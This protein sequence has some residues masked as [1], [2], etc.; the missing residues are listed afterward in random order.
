MT[1]T[2][3]VTLI[4]LDGARPDVFRQLADRGDLPNLSRHLLD[5]PGGGTAS[6]TT[7]FPST[8][9]VAY[10]PF[11]TGCYPGTCDIPGIRWL[12]RRRYRGRWWRD[13]E[14]VR[15]YCGYQRD[16]F[17]RDLPAGVVS[18]FDLEPD[19]VALCT[20]FTRGLGAGREG[21]RRARALWG[22]LAHY[23]RGYGMLERAVGAALVESAPRRHRFSFVVFPGVDGITH[24]Y[25]PEH[26]RVLATYR[27]FDR[28]FGEFVAAAGGNGGPD[29]DHLILVASD[30]GL[31]TVA[32]HTDIALALEHLGIPTLRHPFHL[33]RRRPGAAVMVSGNASA[34]VYFHPGAPRRERYPV[35]ALEA[36]LDGVPPGIASRL[37][38]LPG[39]ALVAGTEGAEVVVVGREGRGRLS[40]A[41][42][43]LI[44]WC[45]DGGGGDGDWGD[46]LNLGGPGTRHQ[47]EWLA[48]THRGPFPDA[49]M[50]L[51]QLFRSE[52]TGDLVVIAAPGTDLRADWEIPEHR[53]GHG[54]LHGEHMRCLVAANRPL[55]EPIRTVDLFP[56]MLQHLGHPIP[57]GIDG[58]APFSPP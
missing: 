51:L 43:A 27:E 35:S 38:E 52:R 23:T 31:S 55:P 2:S 53:S 58:T 50:Q 25:H 45:P 6:A 3:R 26:P 15:S 32:R 22:G 44:A 12:D 1:T 40:R 16:R 17:D 33:W 54:S 37:A 46:P 10:L 4:I 29:P 39:V 57:E 11:L 47:R 42:A 19:S 41:G 56:L 34:Q 20:P 24:C 7:V 48:L 30:H 18:M 14:Y 9:G 5:A 21:V 8:T 36:G 13:R 49:P 28:M